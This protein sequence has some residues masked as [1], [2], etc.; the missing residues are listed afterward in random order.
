MLTSIGENSCFLYASSYFHYLFRSRTI[1]VVD[2]PWMIHLRLGVDP[3]LSLGECASLCG[4][5]AWY[6]QLDGQNP[7]SKHWAWKH[8][9][10][11]VSHSLLR[12]SRSTISSVHW[13]GWFPT[14]N[15][16]FARPLIFLSLFSSPFSLP[17]TD[18]ACSM[19]PAIPILTPS[20]IT[21]LIAN[22]HA[23]VDPGHDSLSKL[24]LIKFYFPFTV[25]IFG[26]CWQDPR[27]RFHNI[28]K[29]ALPIQVWQSHS[30]W[31]TPPYFAILLLFKNLGKARQ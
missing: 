6:F 3:R 23:N 28:R 15:L 18:A 22:P 21:Y 26:S 31:E 13:I 2:S 30:C 12:H 10:I 24:I 25:F 11:L 20:L 1:Q 7:L 14:T 8:Q 16:W 17:Q 29:D 4:I 19:F 9:T 5:E 27:N